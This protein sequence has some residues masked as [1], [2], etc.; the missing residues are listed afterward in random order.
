MDDHLRF[1]LFL[2]NLSRSARGVTNG[3]VPFLS[4]R[5]VRPSLVLGVTVLVH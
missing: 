3:S 1:S 5:P 4:E 2:C